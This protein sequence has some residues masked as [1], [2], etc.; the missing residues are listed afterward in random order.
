V[1]VKVEFLF[2]V[3]IEGFFNRCNENVEH[4]V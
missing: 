4:T 3:M 2:R 1:F